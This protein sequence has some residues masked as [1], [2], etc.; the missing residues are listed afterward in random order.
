MS[1][2]TCS[3]SY[4]CLDGYKH[5]SKASFLSRNMSFLRQTTVI[6][7]GWQATLWSEIE[8]ASFKYK[9]R[10][11][12]LSTAGVQTSLYMWEGHFFIFFLYGENMEQSRTMLLQPSLVALQ[13]Q[14]QGK[15]LPSVQSYSPLCSWDLSQCQTKC[16]HMPFK[17]IPGGPS[18]LSGTATSK[19]GG[20]QGK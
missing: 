19:Q 1:L 13:S 20:L 15:S 2:S 14:R 3:Q 8:A 18:L 6:G 16:N 7:N 5:T 4:V 12:I 17:C 10:T 9:L 11:I